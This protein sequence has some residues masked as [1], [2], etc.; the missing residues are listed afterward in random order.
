MAIIVMN[1]AQWPERSRLCAF[2]QEY[3]YGKVG[4]QLTP[5][6][7]YGKGTVRMNGTLYKL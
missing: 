2:D 7:I 3:E 6:S 4:Q 5:L 1:K